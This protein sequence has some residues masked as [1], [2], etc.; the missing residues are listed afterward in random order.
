MKAK[1]L[2]QFYDKDAKVVRKKDDIFE[3]TPARFQEITL[4]GRY[5]APHEESAVKAATAGKK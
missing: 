3:V 5:I 1:V 2:M 4:K